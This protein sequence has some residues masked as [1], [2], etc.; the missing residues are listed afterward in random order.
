MDKKALFDTLRYLNYKND[1]A[2]KAKVRSECDRIF[3]LVEKSSID[4]SKGLIKAVYS[5]NGRRRYVANY[6]SAFDEGYSVERN[7]AHQIARACKINFPN[8]ALMIH[9]LFEVT[10]VLS[11]MMNFTIVRFDFKG[12][13]YSVKPS[14]I[15][16]SFLKDKL[17]DYVDKALIKSFCQKIDLAYPGLEMSNVMAEMAAIEFDR[18]LK[19]YVSEFGIL[20]YG[21]YVDDGI[22]ILKNEVPQEQLLSCMR[23]ALRETYKAKELSVNCTTRFHELGSSKFSINTMHDIYKSPLDLSFLGYSFRLEFKNNKLDVEYGIDNAK[24]DKYKDRLTKVL[25]TCSNGKQCLLLLR[26]HLSRI[27]YS[28]KENEIDVW[29]ERGFTSTYKEL[30]RVKDKILTNTQV[31]LNTIVIDAL[32]NSGAISLLSVPQLNAVNRGHHYNLYQTLT[33]GNSMIF[34]Y[35]SRIGCDW[36]TLLSYVKIFHGSCKNIDYQVLTKELL[37]KTRIGY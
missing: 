32:N 27:V 37:I 5:K 4:F 31:A 29:K 26:I 25:K 2:P 18:R 24:L 1:Q 21:R 8:R 6:S 35:H 7:L 23:K 36:K 9:E 3:A 17:P 22:L 12:Y 10:K 15:W 20:F 13:F 33:F 11:L 16:E 14:Y 19:S 28:V 34:D 30:K